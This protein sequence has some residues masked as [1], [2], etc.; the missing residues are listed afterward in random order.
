[1]HL[2]GIDLRIDVAQDGR[3]LRRGVL[4]LQDRQ[5]LGRYAIVLSEASITD[6]R[7]RALEL[8]PADCTHPVGPDCAGLYHSRQ[9][10]SDSDVEALIWNPA[11]RVLT[12]YCRHAR[13]VTNEINPG[14]LLAAIDRY[15][16]TR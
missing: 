8:T 5:G 15:L 9:H 4:D 1:M 7:M 6:L 16:S 11:T 10:K 14:Q 13:L 12:L 2:T 3:T